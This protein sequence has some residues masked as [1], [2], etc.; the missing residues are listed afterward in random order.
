MNPCNDKR[1]DVA[2]TIE[3]RWTLDSSRRTLSRSQTA[4]DGIRWSRQTLVF[5]RQ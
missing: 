2:H 5:T 3:E 4:V 1:H